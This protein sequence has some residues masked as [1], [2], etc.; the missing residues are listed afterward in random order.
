MTMADDTIA[1]GEDT[2]TGT[3]TVS[4]GEDTVQG[5]DTV[6]GNGEDTVVAEPIQYQAFE[7]PEGMEVD[8]DALA[9]FTPLLQEHKIPQEQAQKYVNIHIEALKK[10]AEAHATAWTEAMGKWQDEVKADPEIG[11]DHFAETETF[12]ALALKKLGPPDRKGK[13]AQGNEITTNPLQDILK[14]TGT[15]NHVEVVRIL[16]KMGKILADDTLDFGR[17][18]GN[19]TKTRAERMFPNQGQ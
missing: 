4:G 7:M 18:L 2:V 15:G 8:A 19:P 5:Q 13:D 3:D 17:H 12:V 10:Q 14:I 16:R 6:S 1:G 11:G 9:G